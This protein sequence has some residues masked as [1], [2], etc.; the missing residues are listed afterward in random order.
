M[1]QRSRNRGLIY[2]R[3]KHAVGMR[4]QLAWAVS[5]A[6]ALD[7]EVNVAEGDLE[8]ALANDLVSI[9]DLRLDDGRLARHRRF[10]GLRN[11]EL[12]AWSN[13]AISHIFVE[14]IHRLSRSVP[15]L[16]AILNT[17][18]SFG[19][20]VVFR[21]PFVFPSQDRNSESL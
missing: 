8:K 16:V 9:N 17:L 1:Q 11:L 3:A 15:D 14:S 13:Q 7:I 2:V 5:K 21:N 10:I 18:Q 4:E 12:D 6:A 20:R 19:I